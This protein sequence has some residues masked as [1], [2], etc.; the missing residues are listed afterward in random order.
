MGRFMDLKIVDLCS[1][2]F[3]IER[4]GCRL[5]LFHCIQIMDGLI[6]ASQ[7]RQKAARLPHYQFKFVLLTKG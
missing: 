4:G 5:H 1:F 2:S 6:S 3:R 7:E